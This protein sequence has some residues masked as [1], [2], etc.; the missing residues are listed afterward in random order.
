MDAVVRRE[1]T[2]RA[3]PCEIIGRLLATRE[4]C[5]RLKS[6][7]VPQV[8]RRS[9]RSQLFQSWECAKHNLRFSPFVLREVSNELKERRPAD[10]VQ[11]RMV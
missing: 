11:N 9:G 7:A 6:R 1:T 10:G 2:H 3:L 8:L 5:L 4:I